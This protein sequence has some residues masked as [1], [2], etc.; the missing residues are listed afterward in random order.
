MEKQRTQA[1]EILNSAIE[2]GKYERFQRIDLKDICSL[3]PFPKSIGD[4]LQIMETC[5]QR[6]HRFG[7]V[8]GTEFQAPNLDEL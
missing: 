7:V 2:M 1:R 5:H 4:L 3:F 8:Q 6:G